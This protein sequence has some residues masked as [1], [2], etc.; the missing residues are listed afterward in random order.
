M[1]K[2]TLAH[3]V[4]LAM[5]FTALNASAA[6]SELRFLNEYSIPTST[7]YQNAKFGGLSGIAY[8]A[9][10]QVYYSISD[11]RNTT[12]EGVAR[13]YTLKI[14]T[15]TK[16]IKRVDILDMKALNDEAGNAFKEQTVDGEGLAL[17]PDRKSLLWTS[18]LGSP[19][20]LSSLDGK[21]KTDYAD[22][23]PASYNA[24]GDLKKAP[25]GLRNGAT[26]EGASVT[27]SGK[28]LYVAAESALK[29]DGAISTTVNSSPV[30]I[31]KFALQPDGRVGELLAEFIY[32]VDPIPKVTKHGVSDNGLSEILAIS[33]DKLIVTE[34]A[35]R[36]ASEGFNEF[37]FT[38]RTYLSD[39]SQASN[40]KGQKSITEIEKKNLLQ[41]ATKKLLIDFDDYTKAPDCIEAMTFGPLVKGKKSLI[42]VSDNNFQPY[43]STKFFMF[44]DDNGVL[45]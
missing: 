34:R 44:V 28:Y 8:D 29:Q 7:S 21:M 23:I 33:D 1:K 26:F 38:I 11:A 37:D 3:C 35:G 2:L 40:I 43:Q 24:G 22:K 4:A 17:T 27:P 18:E 30:R 39:L 45:N 5:A 19:L 14:N 20:R 36:N 15:N 31:L 10:K 32:N 16:G 12:A 42:F 6:G 9:G 25:E 13:F 41:P